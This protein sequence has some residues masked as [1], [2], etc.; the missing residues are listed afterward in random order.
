MW[1]HA[2]SQERQLP[3]GER[4]RWYATW[5]NAVEGNT[6][7]DVLA[8]N[9]AYAALCPGFV[10]GERNLVKRIFLTPDCCNTAAVPR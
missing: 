2:A 8:Y 1:T 9:Q 3:P 5:C 4:L 6:T 7:Y 10:T